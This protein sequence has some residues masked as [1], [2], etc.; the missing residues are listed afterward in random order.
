MNKLATLLLV[1]GCLT[2]SWAHAAEVVPNASATPE[3][4]A[5]AYRLESNFR[6]L[7]CQNE[8][9]ADSTADLAADLRAIIREQ[10]EQGATDTQIS[11]YMVTRYGDF[12]LYD[13]PFKTLTWALWLGPFV[14]LV[15]GFAAL[16]FVVSG[17]RRTQLPALTDL[18]R[19]RARRLLGGRL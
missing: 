12:V 15:L 10:V 19:R 6:C 1:F 17:R 9:I 4:K 11:D 5:R 2:R 8:T 3:V 14:L 16:V 13:P 7:V 18:E